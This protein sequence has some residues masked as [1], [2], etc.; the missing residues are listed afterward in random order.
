VSDQWQIHRSL[1]LT[2]GVR[3]D[4]PSI[5]PRAPYNPTIDSLFG[6]RTDDLPSRH[7]HLSPRL[8]FVWNVS[9]TDRDRVRGGIGIFT[10]RPPPLWLQT[11]LSSY[12]VG[13]GSLRCGS[14]ATDRGRAPAF[15][16]D[17]RN[18]PTACATGP[19]LSAEQSGDVDLLPRDL[20]MAQ[21]LRATLAYDRDLPGDVL[22]TAEVVMTRNISDFEFV[23]LNL[24]GPQGTDQNGRVL[25]GTIVNGIASP[26]TRSRFSEVIDLQNT[27]RNRAWQWSVRLEKRFLDGL[28]ALASYTRSDVR[29]VQTLLRT[30][31]RGTVNWSSRAVSGRHE[32]RRAGISLND[33]PHR[34]VLA[35]TL[36][37]PWRRTRTE[38]AFYYVGESGNPF[39]YV[40]HGAGTPRGDLNADGSNLNDPIYVPLDASDTNEIRFTGAAVGGDNSPVAQAARVRNQQ[41]AFERLVRTTPCLRRQRGRIAER[42]SCREPWTHSTVALVRQPMRVGPHRVDAELQLFNVLNLLDREW[43]QYRLARPQVL[44]HVGYT[45]A[46][47]G[48]PQPVFRFAATSDRWT[49]LESES[50]FQLQLALRYRF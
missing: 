18:A 26:A 32:D 45:P 9:G 14:L 1:S 7:V 30:G 10:G 37:A 20:R 12:G 2:F 11:A 4:L 13:T 19:G 41:E 28:S 5:G 22:A 21:A 48:L 16:P 35:G 34:F 15:E 33:V 39:T 29:D 44:E 38:L 49:T 42:N 31:V 23:N 36:R 25:Y 8:G 27:S 6:R 3:A 46:A 47:S 40:A 50:R 17:L 24:R 43:G